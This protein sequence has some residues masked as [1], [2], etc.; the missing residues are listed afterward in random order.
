MDDGLFVPDCVFCHIANRKCDGSRILLE[1]ESVLLFKDICPMAP[2]HYQCIP[3]RHIKN[4]N[5][6]NRS[7]IP[8]LMEMKNCAIEYL[9][10][11]EVDIG[12]FLLGFHKPPFNSVHHLHL[13]VIGPVQHIRFRVKFDPALFMFKPIDNLIKQLETKR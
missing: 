11:A 10:T 12:D 4:I 6:L 5:Q 13:H 2:H 8:L 9:K 1:K 3:K 7:N